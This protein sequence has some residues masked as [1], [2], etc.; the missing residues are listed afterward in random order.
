MTP[1]ESKTKIGF[2]SCPE[3]FIY[4]PDLSSDGF[5]PLP[6]PPSKQAFYSVVCGGA[7]GLEGT[8]IPLA[9]V[10][11]KQPFVLGVYTDQISPPT[12]GFS[13]DYTQL[14]C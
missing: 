8:D 14:P 9:L 13:L 4:I 3:S 5:N 1:A 10:S 12:A 11:A 7:F 2:N 6:V